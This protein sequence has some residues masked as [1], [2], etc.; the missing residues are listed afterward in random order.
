LRAIKPLDERC[1]VE[2]SHGGDSDGWVH[3]GG[4]WGRRHAGK[5]A[6]RQAG[7]SKK[8]SHHRGAEATEGRHWGL[9]FGHWWQNKSERGGPEKR[10]GRS[11]HRREE[12][13][14]VSRVWSDEFTIGESCFLPLTPVPSPQSLLLCAL[15]VSV[16]NVPLVFS[17]CSER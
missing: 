8:R 16:V 15:C 2:V 5:E 9:G 4:Y 12:L 3:G 6:G 11:E 13:S 14:G 10:E 17:E 7:R 1:G